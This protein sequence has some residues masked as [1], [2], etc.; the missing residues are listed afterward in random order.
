M[1]SPTNNFVLT[2]P[3]RISEPIKI[4]WTRRF[5][6]FGIGSFLDYRALVH[7]MVGNEFGLL[8]IGHPNCYPLFGF[9]PA[10]QLRLSYQEAV[11]SRSS[12]RRS[13]S[14]VRGRWRSP[15][16]P[17]RP[18]RIARCCTTSSAVMRALSS[19][20]RSA[21]T[22]PPSRGLPRAVPIARFLHL[23]LGL[24][25]HPRRTRWK[26]TDRSLRAMDDALERLRLRRQNSELVGQAISCGE[27][28]VMKEIRSVGTNCPWARCAPIALAVCAACATVQSGPYATPVGP[29]GQPLKGNRTAA[30]LI[31]SGA[32]D[33]S[34]SSPNFGFIVVT[35]QND[36]DDWVR[37]ERV[38]VR[39]GGGAKDASVTIPV[40]EKLQS[41]AEAALQ[42]RTIRNENATLILGALAVAG[43]AVALSANNRSARAAGASVSAAAEAGLAASQAVSEAESLPP[44]HL[45][46]VP[47]TIPP[48]LFARRWIALQT[49]TSQGTPCVDAMLIDYQTA[50][51]QR[52]QV[53]VRFFSDS[54]SEWQQHTCPRPPER[55]Q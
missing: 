18:A 7:G 46:S 19:T 28:G 42:L 10:A 17:S 20:G 38:N 51:A 11:P 34:Y 23:S 43:S 6:Q 39:F 4:T 9:N 52:E 54:W 31:I 29:A 55:P 45:L 48:H 44:A 1:L 24:S 14:P 22:R 12:W 25:P 36:T 53:W 30:G 32:E 21:E 49:P 26:R 33:P 35:F 2:S 3:V 50:R 40:G 27:R 16:G 13:S 15:N 5:V 47:F 37:V 41:W 8:N